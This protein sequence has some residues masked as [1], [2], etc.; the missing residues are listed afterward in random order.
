MRAGARCQFEGVARTA[1]M[2]EAERRLVAETS[3]QLLAREVWLD[4]RE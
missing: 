4:G 2:P 3:Q 1:A